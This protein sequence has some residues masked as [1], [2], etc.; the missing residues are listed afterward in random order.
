VEN[1]LKQNVKPT[2]I[3]KQAIVLELYA[4]K[5]ELYALITHIYTFKEF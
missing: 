2:V 1:S 5:Y 4:S 3:T